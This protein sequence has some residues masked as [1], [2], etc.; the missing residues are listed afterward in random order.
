MQHLGL[1]RD[2]PTARRTL[3][4]NTS[5]KGASQLMFQTIAAPA[6]RR[7]T[8]PALRALFLPHRLGMLGITIVSLFCNFWML[9]QNGFGNLFYAATVKSMG[10]NWHAFFFASFDPAGF[11]TVD[12]PPLGFWLQVAST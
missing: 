6:R 2:W 8:L 12:K 1:H 11:V 10:S 7:L 9:G 4:V 3:I 5:S